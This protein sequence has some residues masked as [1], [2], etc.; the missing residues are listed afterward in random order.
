MSEDTLA[1]V[2][3][4]LARRSWRAADL[5]PARELAAR[6]GRAG[7]ALVIPAL[8][9]AGTIGRIVDAVVASDTAGLLDEI[10]VVDGGSTDAT[11][12]VAAK[13]GARVVAARG[14]AAGYPAGGKGGSVWRALQAT[15]SDVL[16]FVDADLDPFDPAWVAA[17]AAPLLI[18]PGVQLVKAAA[19]RPLTVDGIE[20]P[21]SGG[22]VTELVARPLINAF[23]PQLAGLA[24]PL[25]GEVAARREL[26]E[27]IPIATGYGLEIAMLVDTLAAAGLDGIGQVD[28]GE[29]RHRHH[30]DVALGRM[31]SAVLRTALAR[32]GLVGLPDTL[33]QPRRNESGR[34]DAER[35]DVPVDFLPPVRTLR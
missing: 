21:R 17:L 13:A 11:A 18:E 25:A 5:P 23:W 35:R 19:D 32:Q 2:Q 7:V 20:H 33:I 10:V 26:L 22:R 31:A 14:V 24:Q 29:R 15:T 1:T 34:L 16:V 9:E 27:S 3:R 30:S 6:T 4:W 12:S 28:L 8:D